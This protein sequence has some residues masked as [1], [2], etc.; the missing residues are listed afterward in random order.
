MLRLDRSGGLLAAAS[1]RPM[2]AAIG[3]E[4][5]RVAISRAGQQP[6][7]DRASKQGWRCRR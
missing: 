1:V 7:A 6:L 2:P 5:G 3:R 4:G